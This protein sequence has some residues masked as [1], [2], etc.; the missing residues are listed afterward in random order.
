[1]ADTITKNFWFDQLTP[2]TN[3]VRIG[4]NGSY[5]ATINGEKGV[6]CMDGQQRKE[7]QKTLDQMV[8]DTKMREKGY[9]YR[10][11]PVSKSFEPL[12]A[13][14][15][16]AVVDLMRSYRNDKFNVVDIK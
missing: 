2:K 13:K 15:M 10:L 6:V 9:I 16:D 4:E 7:Q 1:M 5:V 3:V 8:H 12:Y 11:D 14:N